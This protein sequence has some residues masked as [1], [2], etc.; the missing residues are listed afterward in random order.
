MSLFFS[1]SS[2]SSSESA[3]A[4]SSVCSLTEKNCLFGTLRLIN[5][6]IKLTREGMVA[7]I[8]LNS[9]RQQLFS[10]RQSFDE[11][12]I[13]RLVPDAR[14]VQ[15]SDQTN[16]CLC[17]SSWPRCTMGITR[18]QITRAATD[19]HVRQFH[20]IYLINSRFYEKKMA[21]KPFPQDCCCKTWRRGRVP[22]SR[23]L[24]RLIEALLRFCQ[25]LKFEHPCLK[26]Q[27][28]SHLAWSWASSV[29]ALHCGTNYH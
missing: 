24:Q 28:C 26:P 6:D 27:W 8:L 21:T 15:F 25:N 20:L 11:G 2:V 3:A 1:S 13:H 19:L 10:S 5:P 14:R 7:F 23:C 18:Q 9:C 4:E 16:L 29:A 12:A 22:L 17:Q